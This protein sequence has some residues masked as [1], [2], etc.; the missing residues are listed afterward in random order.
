MPKSLIPSLAKEFISTYDAAVKDER[1]KQQQEKFR[2]FWA[3]RVLSPTS[4]PLSEDECDEII[5]ILDTKAKGHTKITEGVARVMVTQHRWRSMLKELRGDQKLAVL[6][7]RIFETDNL[8][9]RAVLIDELYALNQGN[10][11]SLTGPLGQRN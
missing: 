3:N 11:N 4:A 9:E 8:Q 1:W 5:R 7:N 6:I 10:R 2:S